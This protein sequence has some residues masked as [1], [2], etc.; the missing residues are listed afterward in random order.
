MSTR[1]QWLVRALA[2]CATA[3]STLASAA[4]DPVVVIAHKDNPHAVDRAFVAAIYTGRTKGWPDGSPV[5]TLDQGEASD[6]RDDFYRLFV[7]RSVANIQALWAQNIF[8]GKALPP[9]VAT[10]GSEM[11]R[12]VANNRHA[13]GYVRAS[14]VDATV[15]V[16]LR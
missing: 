5:F 2:C 1:R 3:A 7:G 9:K 4:D 12:I 16:L 13:I 8:A 14:E 6:A 11:R 10:P 15:R